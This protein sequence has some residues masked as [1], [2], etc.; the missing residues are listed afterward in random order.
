MGVIYLEALPVASHGQSDQNDHYFY[1][2]EDGQNESEALEGGLGLNSGELE[3]A[4][5]EEYVEDEGDDA[6]GED[7]FFAS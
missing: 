5:V 3:E 2:G 4:G 6:S 1:N 7:D